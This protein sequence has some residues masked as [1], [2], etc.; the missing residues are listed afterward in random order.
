M[1]TGEC[2]HA[3]GSRAGRGIPT[4]CTGRKRRAW[5]PH[6]HP[7][8]QPRPLSSLHSSRNSFGHG[9]TGMSLCPTLSQLTESWAFP[10]EKPLFIRGSSPNLWVHTPC[11]QHRFKCSPK[12][13]AWG[14]VPPKMKMWG[15]GVW[16]SQ[17]FLRM[18]CLD[19]VVP[20]RLK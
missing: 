5:N 17:G 19:C 1:P 7:G 9:D 14:I 15:C 11:E 18:E 12:L 6:Q 3:K 13:K 8:S 2:A 10:R 4:C 16:G 20:T